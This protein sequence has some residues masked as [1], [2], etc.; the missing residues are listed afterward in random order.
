MNKGIALVNDACVNCHDARVP[1][2]NH[3]FDEVS[4]VV[5]LV[6]RVVDHWLTNF[7]S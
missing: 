1:G 6:K 3:V 2:K 5:N 7:F 4:G